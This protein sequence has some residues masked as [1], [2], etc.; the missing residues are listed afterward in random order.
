MRIEQ[1]EDSAEALEAPEQTLDLVAEFVRLTVVH[2]RS[3]PL[4]VAG[5][6]ALM[7]LTPWR[8]RHRSSPERETSLQ[9]NSHVIASRSSSGSNNRRLHHHRSWA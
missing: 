2:P 7:L 6:S 4:G 8:R 1:R 5:V 3:E 9:R